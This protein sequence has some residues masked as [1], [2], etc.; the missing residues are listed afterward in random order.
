MRNLHHFSNISFAI[1]CICLASLYGAVHATALAEESNSTVR[2]IDP[3]VLLMAEVQ[4]VELQLLLSQAKRLAIGSAWTDLFVLL[5]PQERHHAGNLEFDRLLALSA[6]R[7]GQNTRAVLAL[8]RALSA[9]PKDASLQAELATMYFQGG[10]NNAAL[11]IFESLRQTD[12]PMEVV[13]RVDQFLRALDDRQR[14]VREG[15]T[16]WLS[17]STGYDS[18]VNSGTSQTSILIPSLSNLPFTPSD[19]LKATGSNFTNTQLGLRW[20]NSFDKDVR[21]LNGC[22]L[23]IELTAQNIHYSSADQYDQQGLSSDTSLGC[24]QSNRSREWVFGYVTQNAWLKG[25]ALRDHQAFR[26]Q[27]FW[28]FSNVSQIALTAQSGKQI[29]QKDR[30]RGGT[31]QLINLGWAAKLGEQERWLAGANIA[32]AQESPNL[33]TR[34]YQ[35]Y[36]GTQLQAHL[37]YRVNRDWA[38]QIFGSHDDRRH[39]E[40]DSLYV[41]KR[42]DSDNLI[43]LGLTYRTSK[44]SVLTM[45]HSLQRNRS[46]QS[47]YS[48]D[49]NT[50]S[51]GWRFSF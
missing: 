2:L 14:Q 17:V 4:E 7:A 42:V 43:A 15:F 24:P 22:R 11:E 51:L 37:R 50:T 16:P 31:R 44:D 34:K 35:G 46:N 23:V 27:H 10:E 36:V 48:F 9:D 5:A 25:D 28:N 41:T 12:L 39:S 45:S 30:D 8:E 40:A 49:R 20:V 47:L 32:V 3:H 19:S 33:S 21:I 13:G 6:A 38:V 29:F 1:K 26:V 18:N